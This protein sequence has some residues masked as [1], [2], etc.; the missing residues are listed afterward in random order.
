MPRAGEAHHL[1]RYQNLVYSVAFAL[2]GLLGR[3]WPGRRG[4]A[5]RSFHAERRDAWFGLGFGF[6]FRLGLGLEG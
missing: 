3:E 1:S 6:G 2:G 4:V 5:A